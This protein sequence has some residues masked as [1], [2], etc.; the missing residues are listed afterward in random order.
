MTIIYLKDCLTFEGLLTFIIYQNVYYIYC[1]YIY[2]YYINDILN[3]AYLN[4]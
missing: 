1:I 4:E 3:I 2:I